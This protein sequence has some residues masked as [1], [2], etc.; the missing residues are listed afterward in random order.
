MI[1]SV[2][3]SKVTIVLK[4]V[5]SFATQLC[6]IGMLDYEPLVEKPRQ[7]RVNALKLFSAAWT[8]PECLK[9]S[10]VSFRGAVIYGK[11]SPLQRR[12]N[13]NEEEEEEE[14]EEMIVVVVVVVNGH[15]VH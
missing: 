15:V 14:E 3:L 5:A 12:R 11:C 13:V 1:Q 8:A 7:H 6:C 9:K 2:C 10:L 4:L